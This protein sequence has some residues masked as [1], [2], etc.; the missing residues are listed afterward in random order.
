VFNTAWAGLLRYHGAT[1][2]SRGYVEEEKSLPAFEG[3][4]RGEEREGENRKAPRRLRGGF[5][6]T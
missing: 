2:G 6:E 5:R 1:I 4:L 3:D